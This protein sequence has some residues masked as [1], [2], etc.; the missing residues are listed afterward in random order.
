MAVASNQ[1]E[2]TCAGFPSHLAEP[3]L[4]DPATFS[5]K[6]KKKKSDCILVHMFNKIIKWA[7]PAIHLRS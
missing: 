4:S 3:M 2:T 1:V 7:P 6:K 5:V